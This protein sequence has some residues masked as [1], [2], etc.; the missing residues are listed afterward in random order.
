MQ[1]GVF[2][3][4]PVESVVCFQ[5][6]CYNQVPRGKRFKGNRFNRRKT[7]IFGNIELRVR[8]R[9]LSLFFGK[10]EEIEGKSERF[11]SGY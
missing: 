10:A 2:F 9:G 8:E 11:C 3:S 4:A 1:A 6:L 5:A 7:P